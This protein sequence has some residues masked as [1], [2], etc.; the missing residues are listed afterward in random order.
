MHVALVVLLLLGLGLQFSHWLKQMITEKTREEI[1]AIE[2]GNVFM[3]KTAFLSYASVK[4]NKLTGIGN[5]YSTCLK[6][7][8]P[9]LL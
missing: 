3:F 5:V 7:Y 9:K 1:E 4:K 2:I 8:L 6:C